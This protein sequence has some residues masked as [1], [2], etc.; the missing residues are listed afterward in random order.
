[1]TK[2]KFWPKPTAIPLEVCSHRFGAKATFSHQTDTRSES[3]IYAAELYGFKNNVRLGAFCSG[4]V[5]DNSLGITEAEGTG[6]MRHDVYFA[7]DYWKNPITGV[8]ELIPDYYATTWTAAGAAAFPETA[9]LG[10]AK[11]TRYPNHGLE[12]F[13][14]TNGRLG[15]NTTT[16]TP[17]SSDLSELHGVTIREQNWL[18]GLTGRVPAVG[19]FRN[20]Q[21]GS[22]V[23]NISGWAAM[24]N[25]TPSPQPVAGTANTF[26]GFDKAGNRLGLPGSATMTRNTWCSFPN[27][28][29]WWDSWNTGGNTKAQADEY[30]TTNL[31]LAL[32]NGGWYRD[33]CHFH[34]A[35][36]NGTIDQLDYFL[37][38]FRS[39]VGSDFVWTCSYGEAIEYMMLRHITKRVTAFEKAGKVWLMAEIEDSFKGTFTNGIAN[40]LNLAGLN[41]PL[42]VKVNLAGTTLAGKA[43]SASYSKLLAL[44]GDQY[45]VE[46]PY[47]LK[48][49]GFIAVCLTEGAN[50]LHSAVAPVGVVNVLGSTLTVETD[51]PTR[52]VLFQVATG[53]AE[54][55]S[56]PAAR[57]NKYSTSHSFVITAGKDYRIGI[58][59]EMQQA[60]LIGPHGT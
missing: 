26:Y 25:S 45:I 50:G 32:S 30:F 60:A 57:S 44:G 51:V 27:S 7:T 10:A 23:P 54:Y 37:A 56:L 12:L 40:G 39:S 20:G 33:F 29:R 43:L 3:S 58:I 17:G 22:A 38:L 48:N 4:L 46:L 18:A 5:P 52:A 2:I 13:N 31:A 14:A 19:S 35:R 1:M 6:L 21:A 16:S 34:S 47:S 36:S 15:Y 28:Y 41:V 59:S 49:E 55:D 8:V 24:R 42:S 9:V 53:G 11:A